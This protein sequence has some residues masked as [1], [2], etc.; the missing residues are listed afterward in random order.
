MSLD[1]LGKIIYVEIPRKKIL[2]LKDALA[3]FNGLLTNEALV[4]AGF[5]P[6]SGPAEYDRLCS[7]IQRYNHTHPEKKLKILG[8]GSK[9]EGLLPIYGIESI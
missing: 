7:A 3:Q 6:D 5:T 8:R 2:S 9:A 4:A 1:P